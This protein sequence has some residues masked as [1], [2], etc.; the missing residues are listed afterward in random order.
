MAEI[1]RIIHNQ[2][3]SA[4]TVYGIGRR[5]VDKYRLND[6]DGAFAAAPA[7]PYITFTEDSIIKGKYELEESRTVWDDGEYDFTVYQQIGG[8]PDPLTDIL[9]GSIL[10]AIKDDFIL[11]F[12]DVAIGVTA[13][14]NIISQYDGTGL[15]GDTFPSTQSQLS[16]L[17]NVGAAINRPAAS[18]ALTTGTQSANT[19]AETA[20]LDGIN[21]EHIDTAGVMDLYYEFNIGSGISSSVQVSGYMNGNND[22]IDVYGYDWVAAAWVQI[23]NIDGQGSSVNQVNSFDMFIDM[24]GSGANSGIVR[25]RFYKASGLTSAT[26]AIDQIFVAFNQ[27]AEGYQNAAIWFDSNASNTN[28]IRG[29]DGTATNPVSTM[30]AVNTLLVSTNLSR[31]EVISGSTITLAASQND[32]V[33]SGENWTLALGGQDISGSS[34]IG[35]HVSGIATGTGTEQ[36]FRNC[37][38]DD[39][40]HIKETHFI[41]CGIRGTQIAGEAGDYYFDRPHSAIAGTATWVFDFGSAIGDTNLNWRNGSGGIQLESMGDTGTD[42]AS[43]EGRG[44][45]IEGTCTSGVVAV[46]GNFETSGITNLTLV[47]GARYESDTLVKLIFNE[48]LTSANYN[49]KHSAGKIIRELK[50]IAGYEGG[51]LYYDSIAGASGSEDF[52][53]GTLENP[54]DNIA[55]LLLLSISLN[56][57]DIRVLTG[58]SI[59]FAVSIESLNF[60]GENWTLVLGGQSVSG[61]TFHGITDLSGICTGAIKP[62]FEDCEIGDVTFPP[63]H[64]DKCGLSGILTIGSVGDYFLADNCHSSVAGIGS[65]SID[66]GAA[67]GS[68]N[69]NLRGYSGGIEL[70]NMGQAGTD[71]ISIEG[72]GQVIINANSI[73]GTIAI[74]GHQTLTGDAAFIAAGGIISDDARFDVNNLPGF[75]PLHIA[76]GGGT[77]IPAYAEQ[78][79]ASTVVQGDVINLP[80][81]LLGDFSSNRLFFAA[82]LDPSD[83]DYTIG[84]IECTNISYDSGTGKTSYTIPFIA[85]DSEDVTAAIYK[86]ET[87]IRDSDGVS[88]PV[89]GDRYDL[90]LVAQIV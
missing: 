76:G 38:L 79:E 34:F 22:D 45:I 3:E 11:D 69:V 90:N 31:I 78:G 52:V 28:T 32:Q 65:P 23:G 7:D 57:R 19:F 56:I 48:L 25:V 59:T 9:V 29:V 68:A 50:E 64:L 27:T 2:D 14:A 53:N 72:D 70:K 80:R 61:S 47:D 36:T 15:S 60:F 81:F 54:V 6:A 89:T 20:A 66:F 39:C 51:F 62:K 26:L 46:R 87:E 85:S 12:G 63:C 8:S 49:I 21:H 43:I 41:E 82:K 24:V 75:T 1:K 74:R 77:A 55:D 37:H 58:S 33:F 73:G 71:N 40:T 17:T 4:A 13:H 30:S 88:N 5:M 83:D 44:Q 18:Y 16:G 42:T 10:F 67:I 84:L 86:A 35:A